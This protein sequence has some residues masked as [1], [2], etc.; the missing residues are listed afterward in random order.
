MSID[1]LPIF[2]QCRDFSNVHFGDCLIETV[3]DLKFFIIVNTFL[4]VK[5]SL[6]WVNVKEKIRFM[7]FD[8]LIETNCEG[9]VDGSVTGV[10]FLIGLCIVE[11]ELSGEISVQINSILVFAFA[12]TWLSS[13]LIS[14]SVGSIK[15]CKFDFVSDLRMLKE[16][17]QPIQANICCYELPCM[18]VAYDYCWVNSLPWV[19]G[20]IRVWRLIKTFFLSS[21][22]SYFMV[23]FVLTQNVSLILNRSIV[24]VNICH[25]I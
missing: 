21:F 4:V 25:T 15:D 12:L 23:Y 13:G 16:I 22:I 24:G 20:K 5:G 14:H 19:N 10:D 17:L 7:F 11:I 1:G 8:G 18:N 6:T 3:Q 9:L 2:F